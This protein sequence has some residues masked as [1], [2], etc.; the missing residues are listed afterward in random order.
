MSYCLKEEEED[1]FRSSSSLI[2]KNFWFVYLS[3]QS[4]VSVS[5][6]QDIAADS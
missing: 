6:R 5:F 1:I 3:T 4:V 2:A